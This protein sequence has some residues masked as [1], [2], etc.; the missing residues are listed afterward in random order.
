[1]QIPPSCVS[2]E[3]RV[4]VGIGGEVWGLVEILA[5]FLGW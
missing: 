4:G 5:K 3:A 2:T 1:M